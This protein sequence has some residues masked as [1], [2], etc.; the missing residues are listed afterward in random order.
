MGDECSTNPCGTG[1]TCSTPTINTYFCTCDAGYSGGGDK[2]ACSDIDECAANPCGT[3]G[4]C[5]TPT[6]NTYFCTC[7]AG[8]SGGGDKNACS[9]HDECAANSC[10]TGGTCSTPV[11]NSYFCTCENGLYSG[12]GDKTA[13]LKMSDSDGDGIPDIVECPIPNACI[14]T[15]SDGVDDKDDLDS[16]NDGIADSIEKGNPFAGTLT[17]TGFTAHDFTNVNQNLIVV[18]DGGTPQTISVVANCNTAAS[19]A[20]ALNSQITGATVTAVGGNLVVTS[21]TTGLTSTI[22]ITNDGSGVNALA[23]FSSNPLMI[24]GNIVADTD[25]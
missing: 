11:A 23:L 4:T 16:D 5:S 24:N 13:C 19:C 6:I 20:T 10:G 21:D 7:D 9:D 25:S 17:G 3:G 2:T 14:D 1:G 15:D 8:F 12:G 22:S 18:V